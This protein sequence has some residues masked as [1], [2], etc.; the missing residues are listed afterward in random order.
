MNETA[1]SKPLSCRRCGCYAVRWAQT[2]AGRWYMA[3]RVF[4][5]T[6]EARAWLRGGGA[7][8]PHK[9]STHELVHNAELEAREA[10]FYAKRARG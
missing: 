7:R 5:A 9:C 4:D 3:I 2:N 6:P 1:N 10:A 8:R